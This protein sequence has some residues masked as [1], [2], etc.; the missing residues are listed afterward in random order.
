MTIRNTDPAEDA[1]VTLYVNGAI[2]EP[3]DTE[4]WTAAPPFTQLPK[5][6][7]ATV[8]AGAAVVCSV[9]AATPSAEEPLRIAAVGEGGETLDEAE[10]QLPL[11][12]QPGALQDASL[13]LQGMWIPFGVM[14]AS[15]KQQPS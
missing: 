3:Q 5:V 14:N 4:C 1:A 6:Q 11:G 7:P 8:P 10:L 15:Q 12:P 9:H 13:T 2:L